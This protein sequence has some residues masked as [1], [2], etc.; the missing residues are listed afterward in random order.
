M[1]SFAS[2]WE[3]I[4]NDWSATLKFVLI[5]GIAFLIPFI[6][7][8]FVMGLMIKSIS[9]VLMKKEIPDPMENISETLLDGLKYLIFA[10]IISIPLIIIT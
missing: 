1:V 8:I 4:S 9:N 10:G 7:E 6:G 2:V 3:Y 5:A